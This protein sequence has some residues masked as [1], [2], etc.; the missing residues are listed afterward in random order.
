M[1]VKKMIQQF[2]GHMKNLTKNDNYLRFQLFFI[3][4]VQSRL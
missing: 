2:K 4:L 1:K 3:Y